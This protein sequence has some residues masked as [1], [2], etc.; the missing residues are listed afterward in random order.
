MKVNEASAR[1][2]TGCAFNQRKRA[3]LD[4]LDAA[5]RHV[6]SIFPPPG[7]VRETWIVDSPKGCCKMVDFEGV[8]ECACAHVLADAMAND[9]GTTA[10]TWVGR[11]T[12]LT[13]ANAAASTVVLRVLLH[14]G[15]HY[16]KDMDN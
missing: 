10:D 1:G 14:S 6:Y 11:N 4:P 16:G 3:H 12:S 13:F 2:S 5:R 7:H 9:K 15:Q 8:F